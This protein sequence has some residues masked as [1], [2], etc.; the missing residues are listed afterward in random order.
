M[1]KKQRPRHRPHHHDE[2]DLTP[3]QGAALDAA[4]DTVTDAEIAASIRW[5]DAVAKSEVQEKPTHG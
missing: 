1:A 5:L 3:Q 2:I 4:L